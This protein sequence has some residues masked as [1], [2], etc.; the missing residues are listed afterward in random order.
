MLVY[1]KNMMRI[2]WPLSLKDGEIQG[3][4]VRMVKHDLLIIDHIVSP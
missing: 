1:L 2:D 4:K 3:A